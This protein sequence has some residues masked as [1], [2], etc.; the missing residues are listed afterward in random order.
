VKRQVIKLEDL[1]TLSPDGSLYFKGG[2][3][4]KALFAL[5]VSGSLS[6]G[7]ALLGAFGLIVN[8][9][10]WGWLIGASSGAFIHVVANRM[11]TDVSPL[12]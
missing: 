4:T 8:I 1:Y 3:N 2:W 6:I 12:G 11:A 9:G 10:D 7:L 5:I